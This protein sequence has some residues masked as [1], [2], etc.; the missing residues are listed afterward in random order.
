MPESI[1][2]PC[3]ILVQLAADHQLIVSNPSRHLGLLQPSVGLAARLAGPSKLGIVLIV[4]D[5]YAASP[6]RERCIPVR[7]K[8]PVDCRRCGG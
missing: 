8:T 5:I 7:C 6:A 3:S 2:V 1:R 4:S